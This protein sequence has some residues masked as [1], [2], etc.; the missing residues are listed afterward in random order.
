MIQM[1]TRASNQLVLDINI[2]LQTKR[3]QKIATLQLFYINTKPHM[4]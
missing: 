4:I 3:H 1:S 2:K